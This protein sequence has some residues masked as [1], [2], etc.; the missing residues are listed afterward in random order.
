L[1]FSFK[2]LDIDYDAITDPP[3]VFNIITLIHMFYRM[4]YTSMDCIWMEQDGIDQTDPLKTN[5]Q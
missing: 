4:E 1:N 3:K 5:I 2:V